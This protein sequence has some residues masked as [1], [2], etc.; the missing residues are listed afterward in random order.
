M[1]AIFTS[2][3]GGAH[4]RR[5]L[6][7]LI[8][9]ASSLADGRQVDVHIMTFSFTDAQIAD[10]LADAAAMHPTISIRIIADWTLHA[11]AAGQV[12]RLA[13]M[14]HPNLR[15]RYKSDQPYV[16]DAARNHVRWSYRASRGLL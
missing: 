12:G 14:G 5:R 4:V 7:D 11:E 13:R 6:L 1:E 10:A 2:L 3:A 15:V 8:A 9:E 16:W